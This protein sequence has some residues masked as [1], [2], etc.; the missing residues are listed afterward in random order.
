MEIELS[1]Q[2]HAGDLQE[3]NRLSRMVENKI[4]LQKRIEDHRHSEYKRLKKE[5][6]DRINLQKSL[7]KRE[8]EIK[9][10]LLFYIKSEEE[11]VAKLREEEEARKHEEEEKEEGR[12]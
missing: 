10:K 11:R 7:K 9:R 12:S 1:R 6:D 2:H 4:I 8:I 3:K 5:A